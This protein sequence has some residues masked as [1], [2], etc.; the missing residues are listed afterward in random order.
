M[1]GVQVVSIRVILFY[2]LIT[3]WV[4]YDSVSG[5]SLFIPFLIVFIYSLSRDLPNK[6]SIEPNN[7]PFFQIH[8]I[9]K[10]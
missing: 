9:F 8:N 5:Q 6:D 10:V 1:K 2:T 7:Q 4:L 3:L